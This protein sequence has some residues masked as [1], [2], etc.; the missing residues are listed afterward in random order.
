MWRI[1]S[2]FWTWKWLTKWII[3]LFTLN[4]L[5]LICILIIFIF[6]LRRWGRRRRWRFVW[7]LFLRWIF[8]FNLDFFRL[9]GRGFLNCFIFV[10][11]SLSQVIFYCLETYLL[12]RFRLFRSNRFHNCHFISLKTNIFGWIYVRQIGF[13]GNI[14]TSR[15]YSDKFFLSLVLN[16][17]YQALRFKCYEIRCLNCYWYFRIFRLI[18]C[19]NFPLIKCFDLLI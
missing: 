11:L 14:S 2:I 12:F 7:L 18:N 16:L 5:F 8:I 17:N 10:C 9:K 13:C 15:I 6:F 4:N 19:C 3:Y 1:N